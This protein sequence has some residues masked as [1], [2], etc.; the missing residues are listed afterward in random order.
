MLSIRKMYLISALLVLLTGIVFTQTWQV[1]PG[2][3]QADIRYE[4][5]Y[6]INENTGWIVDG[7]KIYRT[8]DGGNSLQLQFDDIVNQPYFRSVAFNTPQLGW[9]GALEGLLYRTTNAGVNWV[10]MDTMITPRP[11]GICDISVVGNTHFFGSGKYSGP[12]NLIKSTDGGASFE[13]IDMGAYASQL[14]G[15]YFFSANTGFIA[16][17]SNIISEGAVVLYTTDGGNSWLKKF[18]SFVQPE[19]V[20]NITFINTFTGYAAIEN[21]GNLPAVIKT[22]NGGMNWSRKNLVSNAGQLDPIGF[23]NENTGWTANHTSI[24]MWETTNGGD[25]WV[26]LQNGSESIHTIHMLSDSIGYAGGH[27]LLKYTR[28]P[29]GIVSNTLY[30][31]E[32]HIMGQ[33]YPN[34]FNPKT[35]I[36]YSLYRK[37]HVLLEIYNSAGEFVQTLEMG[38][39]NAGNYKVEWNASN[40]PSGIYFYNLLTDEGSFSGKAVLL[41]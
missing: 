31:K 21:F 26:F 1:I 28:T 25:N 38:Y 33:N 36:T 9:V 19:H 7:Q 35:V 41:K 5:L 16:G 14:V 2:I 10:R 4:D 24:G 37:T 22:T 6:F 15:V 20:W 32:M 23:I 27:N 12:T 18:R 40:N 11:I 34:P 29:L 30:P 3:P 13:Y 17:R 39:R 8:T